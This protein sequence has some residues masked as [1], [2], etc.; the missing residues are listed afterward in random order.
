MPPKK[1]GKAKGG[2]MTAKKTTPKQIVR[3]LVVR[4]S[5][6]NSLFQNVEGEFDKVLKSAKKQGE[7]SVAQLRKQV[8]GIIDTINVNELKNLASNTLNTFQDLE[9][10]E[11]AKV[12]AVDTKRQVLSALQIPSQDEFNDLS[13]KV[14]ALE[15]KLSTL[16]RHE[17]RH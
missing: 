16:K 3:K 7:R 8:D 9:L 13:K 15:K 11:L 1:S 4:L 17:V 12:K 5:D 6:F 14:V 10:V 2:Q